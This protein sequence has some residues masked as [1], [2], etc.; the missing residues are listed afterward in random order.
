MSL[1]VRTGLFAG[2][3]VVLAAI[4]VWGLTGL[5]DFGR[6]HGPYGLIINER[7]IGERHVTNL[8]TAV[9]FDYRAFDT[10]GEEFI[11]FAAAVGMAVILRFRRE[12]ESRAPDRA[13]ALEHA[14]DASRVVGL[15]LIA[16]VLL[17][18]FYIVAHGHLTPGGGF[19]GGV[20][21][22]SGF[23]LAYLA[24]GYATMRRVQPWT[25]IEVTK[26][27]GAAGYAIIGLAGLIGAGAF[28]AN[29][30]PLG[31]VGLLQSG[32]TIPLGNLAVSLEVSA[33][34]VL[35]FS[36]LLEQTLVVSRTR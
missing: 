7:A 35:V 8:P 15:A 9:N 23:L 21:L 20:I 32:G 2:S 33:A 12:R 1:R 18:G 24:G 17:L 13:A 28:F 22:A 5:P 27:A 30:L 16:P 25:L 31:P 11:L 29:V 4:L 26:S 10:L 6:Y 3:S 19:Q 36:E 14:T 34:F